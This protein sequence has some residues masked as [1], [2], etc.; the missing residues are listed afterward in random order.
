MFVYPHFNWGRI[1]DY[2]ISNNLT[3]VLAPILPNHL[4]LS[5]HPLVKLIFFHFLILQDYGLKFLFPQQS[6]R[7]IGSS[8]R[9]YQ[10]FLKYHI[11]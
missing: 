6:F 1:V 11:N 9:S 7:I 8:F 4:T 10:Y 2:I 3:E 5:P